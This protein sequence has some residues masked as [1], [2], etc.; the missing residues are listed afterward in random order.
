MGYLPAVLETQLMQAGERKYAVSGWV[1]GG[2]GDWYSRS[3]STRFWKKNW[4][5]LVAVSVL[6]IGVFYTTGLTQKAWEWFTNASYKKAAIVVDVRH[7]SN[8]R[9]I[10]EGLAQGFEGDKMRLNRVSGLV[11]KAGVK[12]VRIDHVLDGYETIGRRSDG[13][14]YYDF[15]H[16]DKLVN[17][18]L[19]MGAKPFFSLSYMPTAIADGDVTAKPRSWSEYAQVVSW[20]VAHYSRD[21]RGGISNVGYEVW[22]EPD[23]FGHWKTYGSKNYLTL[24]ATAVREVERV[25]GAK[26]FLIGGPGTTGF[27]PA[28]A[29]DFYS[30]LRVRRDF[31]SWHR[32]SYRVDDFVRDVEGAKKIIAPLTKTNQKIFITEWG[33]S[34]ERGK[35]YDNRLA[36]AHMAAVVRAL[37]DTPIDLMFAFEIEDG[38]GGSRWHG[39]W[40]MLTNSAYGPIVAKPRWRV[41]EWLQR[42]GG[43]RLALVGE[44]SFVKALATKDSKGKL[45]IILVNY[46]SRWRHSE[47]FPMTIVGLRDGSYQLKESYLSGRRLNTSVTVVGGKLRRD[48]A[49]DPNEVVLVEIERVR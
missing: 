48:Y 47:V 26:P 29:K 38:Q 31:F 20:F 3:M 13:S 2:R 17:D 9:R 6:I 23:L 18:I 36:G 16:L 42:L 39:G 45:E 40:G 49:L 30:K 35:V 1:V 46:D 10:W 15:S 11:R 33:P 21:F 7:T 32:Y 41:Y 8:L 19:A 28:W 14:L 5:S 34:P 4:K 43:K 37:E 27:Y 25:R 44:G 24:Y 22:N 12:Y